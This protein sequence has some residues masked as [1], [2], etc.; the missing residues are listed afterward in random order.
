M[1][2]EITFFYVTGAYAIE[3]ISSFPP[4][5]QPESRILLKAEL[6][7]PEGADPYL[8]WTQAGKPLGSGR[9]SEGLGQISWQAPK[10]G[11]YA[12]QVEL[13]PSP[14]RTADFRFASPWPDHPSC[15]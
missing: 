13:F 7:Y 12:I 5:I 2:K 15:T 8:R 10:E 1:E 9:V 6:R 3:G 4:T 11:V 14:P